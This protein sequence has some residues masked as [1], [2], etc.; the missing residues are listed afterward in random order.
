[1]IGTGVGGFEG[2]VVIDAGFVLLF[3]RL[4]G[5]RTE[6]ARF[7]DLRGNVGI[8]LVGSGVDAVVVAVMGDNVVVAC[9]FAGGSAED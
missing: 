3:S 7:A 2:V 5:L 9:R 1:M 8:W 6:L 4:W